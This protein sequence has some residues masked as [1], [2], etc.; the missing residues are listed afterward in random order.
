[1]GQKSV[2]ENML[3]IILLLLAKFGVG[4]Y[5]SENSVLEN[6][7]AE[8][9][10]DTIMFI[11]CRLNIVLKMKNVVILSVIFILQHKCIVFKGK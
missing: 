11:I 10:P 1:M 6:L 3:D 4:K 2:Q 5:V 9:P 8:K 7:L